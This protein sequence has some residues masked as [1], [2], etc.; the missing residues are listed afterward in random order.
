MR[1]L[2]LF[3]LSIVLTITLSLASFGHGEV[4]TRSNKCNSNTI[5]DLYSLIYAPLAP[6]EPPAS[7]IDDD[8]NV[9]ASEDELFSLIF[10]LVCSLVI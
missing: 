6:F 10:L 5:E 9:T 3:D 7:I 8:G 1:K 2:K 4:S